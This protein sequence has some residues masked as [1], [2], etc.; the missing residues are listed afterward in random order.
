MV[1]AGIP[2]T[3]PSRDGGRDDPHVKKAGASDSHIAGLAAASPDTVA[4]LILRRAGIAPLAVVLTLALPIA[5]RAEAQTSAG[6]SVVATATAQARIVRALARLDADGRLSTTPSS[7]N[8]RPLAGVT[9]SKRPCAEPD[10]AAVPASCL[11][12]V[13]DLP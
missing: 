11:M 8:E 7:D 10:A 1:G 4:R 9:V 13:Y 5:D 6:A 2:G 12:L 3:S